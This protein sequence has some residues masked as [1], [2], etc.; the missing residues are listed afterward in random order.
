MDPQG[1][2]GRNGCSGWGME[3]CSL[4]ESA[5]IHLVHR[6]HSKGPEEPVGIDVFRGSTGREKQGN[7]K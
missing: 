5:R 4:L 2:R 7:R 1:Y 3:Y 6:V